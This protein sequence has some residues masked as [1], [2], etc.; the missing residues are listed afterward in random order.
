MTEKAVRCVRCI[1][2]TS[3]PSAKLDTNGV[4]SFCRRYDELFKR[5]ADDPA[6]RKAELEKIFAKAK[7]LNKPYDCL[8]PL[9]GGKDS[10]HVLYLCDRVYGLRCLCVTFDNGF[11]SDHAKKNIANAIRAT[12][13]DHIFYTI[14]P[15]T[16][17]DFYKIFARKCG[18]FCPVCMRGIEVSTQFAEGKFKPPLVIYGGGRRVSYVGFVPEL[19]QGGDVRFFNNVIRGETNEKRGFILSKP[20]IRRQAHKALREILKPFRMETALLGFYTYYMNIYD[21]IDA[22]FDEI[23]RTLEREMAW[24]SPSDDFEHM[25]CRLH[26][27]P[28]YIHTV[29][30]PQLTPFTMYNSN[31]VRLGRMTREQALQIDEDYLMDRKEPRNID[32]FLEKIGMTRAEFQQAIQGWEIMD[33]YRDKSYEAVRALYRRIAGR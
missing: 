29:R 14:N 5:G 22:S 19:F 20:W 26:D 12:R 7:K 32:V 1:V 16:L 2:P 13:A 17:N 31:L 23:R 24:S 6:R 18:N 15:N 30:F 3:L 28:A 9:S 4:C 10:T 21:Y 33:Q 8:I 25:D 11:L 27:I